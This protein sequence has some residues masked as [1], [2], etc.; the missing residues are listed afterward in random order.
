MVARQQN[1]VFN[2]TK[3]I[4]IPVSF[5]DRGVEPGRIRFNGLHHGEWSSQ[6]YSQELREAV[7]YVDI[8]SMLLL[9]RVTV[10]DPP[11]SFDSSW[12]GCSI[13]VPHE[14]TNNDYRVRMQITIAFPPNHTDGGKIVARSSEIVIVNGP[15]QHEGT[16]SSLLPVSPSTDDIPELC[17]LAISESEGP[18]LYVNARIAGISWKELASD[19]KFKLSVFPGCVRDI[20]RFLVFNPGCHST[21]GA[22]WLELDGIRGRDIPDLDSNPQNVWKDLNDYVNSASEGLMEQLQLGT[23][24]GEALTRRGS[25]Q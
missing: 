7:L 3:R 22:P 23:R 25:E 24:L 13:E 9:K 15:D 17:R 14:L 21:W 11:Q 12:E 16:G 8:R 6:L 2:R 20:L 4:D 5:V 10:S 19:P 18:V 1:A